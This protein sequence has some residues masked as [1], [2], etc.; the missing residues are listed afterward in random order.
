MFRVGYS[1]Q[2]QHTLKR[3]AFGRIAG[4][5]SPCGWYNLLAYQYFFRG[6][7]SLRRPKR[8]PQPGQIVGQ[9]RNPL[10]NRPGLGVFQRQEV[11]VQRLA[12]EG[13]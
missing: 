13:G 8:V 12:S 7:A 3:G 6:P 11:C 4:V 1:T 9:I 5:T 2:V 10:E